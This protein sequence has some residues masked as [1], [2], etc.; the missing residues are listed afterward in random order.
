MIQL[1]LCL[2]YRQN[3]CGVDL[4]LTY[5]EDRDC[6]TQSQRSYLGG[7]PSKKPSKSRVPDLNFHGQ[8]LL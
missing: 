2:Q 4:W 5:P 1:H 3:T 6:S 7:G 8:I